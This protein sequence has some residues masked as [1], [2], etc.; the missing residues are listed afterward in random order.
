[1]QRLLP[2][3]ARD[4]VALLAV[5]CAA[6]LDTLPEELPTTAID[7]CVLPDVI[8]MLAGASGDPAPS[9]PVA[10]AAGLSGLWESA[11]GKAWQYVQDNT[12]AAASVIAKRVMGQALFQACKPS[13]SPPE[14]SYA[15][16]MPMCH[17]QTRTR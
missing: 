10:A 9:A 16:V 3:Q 14:Y 2:L 15:T 7:L 6:A 13:G 5:D 17:F 8:S 11:V 4:P 1:M 12:S